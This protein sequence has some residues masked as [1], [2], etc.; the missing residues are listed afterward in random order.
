[1]NFKYIKQHIDSIIA[2]LILSASVLT[3]IVCYASINNE[4]ETQ[5]PKLAQSNL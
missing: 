4:I 2:V 1:M 5:A 3:S